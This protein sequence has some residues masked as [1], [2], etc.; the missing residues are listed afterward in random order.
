MGYQ[1]R[2]DGSGRPIARFDAA[3]SA[4]V[5]RALL[6]VEEQAYNTLIPPL[7]GRRYVVVK[8]APAGAK[9]GSYRQYTRTGIARLITERGG[10][11]PNAGIFVKETPYQFYAVGASYQYDYLDLLAAAFA[12]E[13]G[14]PPLNLDLEGVIAAQEAIEKKLDLISAVGSQSSTFALENE[15]D[16][17][18]VGLLNLPNGTIYA[19]AAGASG[20][21]QWSSK[22][23]DEI[24][25]DV[26]GIVA[27]QISGTFKVH[28]PKALLLPVNQYETIG[29]RS[30]G[31]GRS[32]TILSYIDRTNKHIGSAN[33]GKGIDSWY[34]LQGAGSANSDR[35]VAYDPD[36][37]FVRHMMAMDFTQLPPQLEGM[38]YTTPCLAKSAGVVSPYPLSVSFGDGI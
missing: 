21:T 24:V 15:I 11:M 4:F 30:M 3:E 5:E 20:Q 38:T 17:G 37:R 6:W 22:T 13:N 25:A 26:T 28:T 32:D 36:P 7:E 27:S 29:G 9:M 8:M 23:P 14:G 34:Y 31:D 18:M 35:M 1:M 19:V 10:D 2:F 16:V 12:A 33:G